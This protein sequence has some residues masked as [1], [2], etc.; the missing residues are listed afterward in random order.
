[1]DFCNSGHW[2]HSVKARSLNFIATIFY[3]V[4]SLLRPNIGCI[5]LKIIHIDRDIRFLAVIAPSLWSELYYCIMFW[6]HEWSYKSMFLLILT[7]N[8]WD[9]TIVVFKL[10]HNNCLVLFP[11][12]GV[13]LQHRKDIQRYKP[14]N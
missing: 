5:G 4:L 7:F 13:I 12:C 10:F 2:E 6:R 9:L 14:I 3:R 1:M 11:S 8:G